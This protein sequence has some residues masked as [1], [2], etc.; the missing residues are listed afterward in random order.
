LGYSFLL[1]CLFL[2]KLINHFNEVINLNIVYISIGLYLLIFT[3]IF[4][5][6]RPAALAFYLCSFYIVGHLSII[7]GSSIRSVLAI[8]YVILILSLNYRIL[9]KF[10]YLYLFTIFIFLMGYINIAYDIYE[11]K[12]R[13]SATIYIW[14]S[15]LLISIFSIRSIDG[16]KSFL[17]HISIYST[18]F[19]ISFPLDY[20]YTLTN[21]FIECHPIYLSLG[22]INRSEIAY[23]TLL[24]FCYSFYNFSI[25]GN[26]KYLVLSLLNILIIIFCGSKAPLFLS[27]SFILFVYYVNKKNIFSISHTILPII[28]VIIFFNCSFYNTYFNF[29]NTSVYHSIFSR[30]ELYIE[31]FNNIPFYTNDFSKFLFGSGFTFSTIANIINGE[32][33]YKAGSGNLFLDSM[34]ELGFFGLCYI[35]YL[36]FFLIAITFKYLSG[37]VYFIFILFIVFTK[38]IL[39]T[40][41]YNDVLIFIMFGISFRLFFEKFFLDKT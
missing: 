8:Y 38:A 23:V 6:S 37:N 35:L 3:K 13:A 27:L 10:I 40:E 22:N 5:K 14:S 19:I 7:S 30:Q 36:F 34:N 9:H 18:L 17:K 26:N 11:L 1:I 31:H 24:G 4:F 25:L 2:I 28:C 21:Y 29:S 32:V 33:I 20:F 16:Y 41:F 39:A 12:I 15:S